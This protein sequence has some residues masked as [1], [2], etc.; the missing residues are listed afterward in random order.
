MQV[1][2]IN[3]P[4]ME[5]FGWPDRL[6]Q[7]RCFHGF[8]WGWS[9]ALLTT[10]KAFDFRSQPAI[11]D[12]GQQKTNEQCLG[13]KILENTKNIPAPWNNDISLAKVTFEDTFVPFPQVRYG[14]SIWM[15]Y[16]SLNMTKTPQ[17]WSRRDEATSSNLT[18][19]Q[20]YP[21]PTANDQPELNETWSQGKSQQR[22]WMNSDHKSIDSH[23]WS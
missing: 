9:I 11:I 12:S 23:K 16:P 14:S 10:W 1:N 8:S 6:L 5:H 17:N 21:K 7:A 13:T 3:N 19:F 2:N 15:V 18:R 20:G 22:F 4:Y